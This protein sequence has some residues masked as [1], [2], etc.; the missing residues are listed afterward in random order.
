MTVPHKEPGP[1]LYPSCDGHIKHVGGGR[2]VTIWPFN[3]PC[4][5]GGQEEH[6]IATGK[7][8]LLLNFTLFG[9]LYAIGPPPTPRGPGGR[10]LYLIRCTCGYLTYERKLYWDFYQLA[11]YI[12]HNPILYRPQMVLFYIMS[13]TIFYP[14]ES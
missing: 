1:I 8:I 9:C 11:H 6:M 10:P 13:A 3:P 7:T 4:G 12:V 14:V 2:E 5:G